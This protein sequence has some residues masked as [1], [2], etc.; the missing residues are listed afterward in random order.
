MIPRYLF[1]IAS[2][3]LET[4]FTAISG[5]ERGQRRPKDARFSP[6]SP[7]RFQEFVAK[8]RTHIEYLWWAVGI[9]S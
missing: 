4:E 8:A 3:F 6:T 9:V 1:P 2:L 7:V 5:P